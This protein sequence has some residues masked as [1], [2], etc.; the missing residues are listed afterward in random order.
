MVYVG[1][2]IPCNFLVVLPAVIALLGSYM[3]C[4][5]EQEDTLKS[6][7]LIPVEEVKLTLS[8]MVLALVFR[9]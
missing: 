3:V 9:Y 2:T 5:E 6:L 1:G 8:K 7:R 4:R